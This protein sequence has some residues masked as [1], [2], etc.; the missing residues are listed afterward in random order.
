MNDL[1][2][3][4]LGKTLSGGGGGGSA[5]LIT[6][7][8]TANGTYD[9]SDDSADGYSAVTVDVPNSYT[10]ADEGKVVSDG[11]LV[12]Q[13]SDTVTT[14]GT[15][16]TTLISSLLVNVQGGTGGLSQIAK[17]QTDNTT[18]T[19]HDMF[20]AASTGYIYIFGTIASPSNP[21][22]IDFTIPSS[23]DA[24]VIGLPRN[25]ARKS[26]GGTTASPSTFEFVS[27]STITIPSGSGTYMFIGTFEKST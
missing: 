13:T 4:L 22:Y 14:N 12:A 3:V 10:Q 8:I 21:G 11:A 17:L 24:S 20:I 23:F 1:Y 9:A 25:G 7:S 16:N 18:I 15:V 5:T 19:A 26:L 27:P 6:K 2:G